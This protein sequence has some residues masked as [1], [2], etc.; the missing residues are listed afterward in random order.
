MRSEDLNI[1]RLEEAGKVEP[2]F[3]MEHLHWTLGYLSWVNRQLGK[4]EED[5]R[6]PVITPR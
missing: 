2:P 1:K 5:F 3:P 4:K 6:S